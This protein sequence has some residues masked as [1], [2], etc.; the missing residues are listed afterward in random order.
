MPNL[1]SKVGADVLSI[2]PYAQTPAMIA[3][4]RIE[5]EA[6][7]AEAVRGSGAD[8]GAV[9]DA[10]GERLTLIDNRGHVLSDDEALMV[11]LELSTPRAR[12]RPGDAPGHGQRRGRSSCARRAGVEVLL[13]PL[14]ASG[15]LEAAAS[16]GV[17]FASDRRGGYVFPA[18]LPAFDAAAALARLVSLLGRHHETL[19]EMV[20]AM[21]PMPIRHEEVATPIEHK[22]LIMR[23]LMEQMTEEGADL[24]L[25]D[26]I[27]VRLRRRLGP[28]R[29]RSRGLRLPTSGPRGPTPPRR[30]RWPPPTPAAWPPS[31]SN[32][33]QRACRPAGRSGRVPPL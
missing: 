33:P 13:A 18:F 3:V 23:T 25:V 7:V 16:G 22:G 15:L 8:L 27:K 21:P 30:P 1:L 20:Q 11:F 4:D 24:V 9:I 10:G 6:R 12:R 19:A 29:A 14:S 28:R 5:S 32:L 26:G 31:C 2:N 17:T